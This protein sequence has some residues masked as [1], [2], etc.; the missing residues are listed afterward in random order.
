MLLF[1]SRLDENKSVM[2][3]QIKVVLLIGFKSILNISFNTCYTA[4]SIV[5]AAGS[6]IQA[7]LKFK[8]FSFLPFVPFTGGA[9]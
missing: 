3:K 9:L 1:T 4:V 5:L 6:E 8:I 7:N 2:S